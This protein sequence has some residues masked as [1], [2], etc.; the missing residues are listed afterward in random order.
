[1]HTSKQL[2]PSTFD[3]EVDGRAAELADLWPGFD[4]HDRVGIVV[5]EPCGATGASLAVLAAV[6]TFYELE[7]SRAEDFL[8]FADHFVFHVG[9]PLGD[10]ASFDIWP[11][12]K[13]V[14][15]RDGEEL[16][17]AVNDRGIT[18]LVVPDAPARAPWFEEYTLAG[19]RRRIVSALAYSP[20]GRVA[21]A[22]VRITGSRETE[23]YVRQVVEQSAAVTDVNA[24]AVAA[25]RDRIDADGRPVETYRR[26]S[27][28][29]ALGALTSG[30]AP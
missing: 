6:T 17:R 19:A 16:L 22:D 1:M 9:R 26:V 10:H 13:E 5:R 11:E 2:R 4:E 21:D 23:S 20:S 25:H 8:V 7:R 27:V 30:A 29:W 18:R 28:D 15:A 24:D 12:H 3:V 14:V